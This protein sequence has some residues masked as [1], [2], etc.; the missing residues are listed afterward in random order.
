MRKIAIYAAALFLFCITT[1]GQV[2]AQCSQCK[3]AAGTESSDGNLSV[4]AT[5]NAGVLYLLALPV[6]L[7]LIVGGLLWW[8][9]R[10]NQREAAA[11]GRA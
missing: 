6:F 9:H 11:Q 10:Q 8:K 3:A 5:L 7:P 2:W 4:G 1:A